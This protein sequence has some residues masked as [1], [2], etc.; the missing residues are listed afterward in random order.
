MEQHILAKTSNEK[1]CKAIKRKPLLTTL[2]NR[3]APEQL[4]TSFF[5]W[6]IPLLKTPDSVIMEKVGL[7]AVVVKKDIEKKLKHLQTPFFCRCYNSY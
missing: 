6:I 5:G 1:V 2:F 7:D 3:H 4:P